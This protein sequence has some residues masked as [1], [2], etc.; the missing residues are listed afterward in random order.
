[1]KRILVL[2]TLG[3]ILI[4][5]AFF[6]AAEEYAVRFYDDSDGLSHWH[7]SQITQD[8]S[9]IIWIAT[10]NGL[11][12]FDGQHFVP[13][14]PASQNNL[15]IPN[16]RIRRVKLTSDNNLIC[17]IDDR[18][19]LFSTRTCLFDTLPALYKKEA[20]E[21]IK[22]RFN[23]DFDR[24]AAAKE[25]HFGSITLQNI[26]EKAFI[27]RQGNHW[28]Y[29]DHGI[30]V[31][32]P[33]PHRG[34]PV[35]N[36]ESRAVARMNNGDIWASIRDT[37]QVLI[38]DSALHLRGYLAPDGQ[39]QPTPVSFGHA[40][41][42]FFQTPQGDIFLGC[43]PGHLIRIATSR[44]LTEYPLIRN[45]YAIQQDS[46]GHLWIATFG[47]GL[48]RDFACIPGTEHL[49][50]RRLLFAEPNT[51]LA[52]TTQG[53]LALHNDTLTLHQRRTDNPASLTSNAI[54]CL[55]LFNGQ[56][57]AGTEGGGLNRLTSPIHD[58]IW[59]WEAW[60]T[61]DGLESDVIFEIIPWSPTELLIQ[62]PN[63]LSLFNTSSGQ[64]INYNRS[65]LGLDQNHKLT[66]GEVPPVAI[67]DTQVLVAP[68][69]GLFLLNKPEL[70]PDESPIRIALSSIRRNGEE[71]FAVDSITSITLAPSERHLVLRFAA[72]DYRN[73]AQLHYRTRLYRTSEAPSAWDTPT[74]S[75]EVILQNIKPG[76]YIFEIS[77][78]NAYGH[79]QPNTRR[80][81]L[82]VKPTFLEST[83]GKTT[84]IV[85][86]ALVTLLLTVAFLQLRFSRKNRAKTLAAYLELQERL[87]R[88]EHQPSAEPL[89]VLDIIAPG[90]TSE[91]E[92]FLNTLRQFMDRHLS[93]SEM[94]LDELA[95]EVNMSRSTLN[96]KMH[97]LF[98]LSAKD[99]I[100]TARM[101]HACQLLTTTDLATKEVAYACGFSDPNYFSK[102]FKANIGHTPTEYREKHKKN[103]H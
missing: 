71:L 31:V 54:M 79:W 29:D 34:T 51:L 52:A 43:K 39:I 11:N 77:S 93:D 27:D 6:T 101:K 50:I 102:C 90:Y 97:E 61:A 37:K 12:R 76:S 45:A 7:I 2:I 95:N 100:Q 80:I 94:T 24:A 89:P 70:R 41:Y 91:N 20:G 46:E 60:K 8:T 14:K 30:F 66:L 55:C 33:Q 62:E 59:T 96:R 67:N 65:F 88:I 4:P 13:F 73:D 25:M 68:A 23:P 16:D 85:L 3:C 57:F 19:Y 69:S 81:A 40:V 87:A 103:E 26:W 74:N 36:K 17:Q 63:A 56:L 49:K 10:W 64:F 83:M 98:N 58:S 78:T 92:R 84:I 53:V 5:A 38:Y 15:G 18:L 99:F 44:Q 9:G 86:I 35:N 21:M 75:S 1:M 22:L 48:W 32:T 72:L 28:L 47:F 82:E 42:S